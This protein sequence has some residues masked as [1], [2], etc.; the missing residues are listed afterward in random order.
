MGFLVSF[1]T[2]GS[3][4]LFGEY[5]YLISLSLISVFS[6]FSLPLTHAPLS[7]S[8]SLLLFSS[9]SLLL[10]T[11]P[12]LFFFIYVSLLIAKVLRSLVGAKARLGLVWDSVWAKLG[13]GL[14]HFFFN[15]YPSPLL[16]V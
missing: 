4:G 10:F 14:L 12:L 7:P 1:S 3:R 9:S 16:R 6:S 11:S 2:I 15:F 8:L 13:L 5:I